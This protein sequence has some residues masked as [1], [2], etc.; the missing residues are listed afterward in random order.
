MSRLTSFVLRHRLL[1]VAFWL[2]L[3]TAGGATVGTTTGR[4]TQSFAMPGS[5]AQQAA[6]KI[7]QATSSR[8]SSSG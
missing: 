7:A 6:A 4:L 1:V 3:A 8:S 2:V 5:P